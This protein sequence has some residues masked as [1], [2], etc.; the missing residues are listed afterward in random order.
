MANNQQ[1]TCT[2]YSTIA[3]FWYESIKNV[4]K[5]L[6]HLTKQ[7]MQTFAVTFAINML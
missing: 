1:F 7:F 5:I 2:S 6:R 3:K 4:K